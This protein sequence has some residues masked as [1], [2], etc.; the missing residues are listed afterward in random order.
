MIAGAEARA[1]LAACRARSVAAA[2]ETRRRIGRDLHDGAQ[3]RLVSLA[4]QL[5]AAQQTVPPELSG[6]QAEL[7]RVAAGL[8]GALEELREYARG[9]HPAALAVGGLA[10]ALRALA[11]RSPLPVT[12][13]VLRLPAWTCKRPPPDS[14]H[15]ARPAQLRLAHGRNCFSAGRK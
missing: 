5:R 13:D 3:Q 1:E 10:P 11:R 7:G 6:L 12:L 4:L 8:T 2:D 14:A 15:V 9:I